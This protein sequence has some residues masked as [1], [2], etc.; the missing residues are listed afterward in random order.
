LMPP[1]NG[2]QKRTQTEEPA[3][4]LGKDD[5]LYS[6]GVARLKEAVLKTFP[7]MQEMQWKGFDAVFGPRRKWNFLGPGKGSTRCLCGPFLWLIP[8]QLRTAGMG[9]AKPSPLLKETFIFS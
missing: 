5:F 1:T 2:N 8:R 6:T 7:G 3:G 4:G 9:Y